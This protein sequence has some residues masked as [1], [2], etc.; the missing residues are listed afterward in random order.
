MQ[1]LLNNLG[2]IIISLAVIGAVSALAVTGVITG[3][4]ALG[5]IAV[6][7]GISIGVAGVNVGTTK[8]P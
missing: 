2:H 7:G 8:T 4:A 3:T 1:N 6:A 5:V